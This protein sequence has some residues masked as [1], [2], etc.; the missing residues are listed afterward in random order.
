MLKAG[1]SSISFFF[2]ED[3]LRVGGVGC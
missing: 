2:F 3:K 1:I